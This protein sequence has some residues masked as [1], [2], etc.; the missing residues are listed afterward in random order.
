MG[1][2][3]TIGK[4]KLWVCRMNLLNFGHFFANNSKKHK[5]RC[6]WAGSSGTVKLNSAGNSSREKKMCCCTVIIMP[7]FESVRTVNRKQTGWN[8]RWMVHFIGIRHKYNFIEYG[9]F[10]WKRLLLGNQA[11]LLKYK[12]QTKKSINQQSINKSI[13]QSINQFFVSALFWDYCCFFLL[14]PFV[15]YS[16][17]TYN[18]QETETLVFVRD[19]RPKLLQL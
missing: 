18:A 10:T 8:Q 6:F 3:Q 16:L 4:I 12:D 14:I 17:W 11:S 2:T 1:M 9:H 13:N 7:Q 15:F 5:N 19:D